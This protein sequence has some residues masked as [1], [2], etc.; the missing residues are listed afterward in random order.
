[1]TSINT[2]TR[3]ANMPQ[4]CGMKGMHESHANHSAHANH[5]KKA[6]TASNQQVAQVEAAR[7]ERIGNKLDVRV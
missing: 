1:M 6:E 3:T 4:N 5:A 7:D 2:A